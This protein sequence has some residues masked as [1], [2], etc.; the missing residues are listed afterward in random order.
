MILELRH[1]ME[2]YLVYCKKKIPAEIV[3][4]IV[5]RIINSEIS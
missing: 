3:D 2:A 4:K 1:W 5:A